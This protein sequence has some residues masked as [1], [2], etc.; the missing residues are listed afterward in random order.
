[1][2]HQFDGSMVQRPHCAPSVIASTR[3]RSDRRDQCSAPHWSL[4]PR[5]I[6]PATR[7]IAALRNESIDPAFSRTAELLPKENVHKETA[8]HPNLQDKQSHR[9]KASSTDAPAASDM[10]AIAEPNTISKKNTP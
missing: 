6:T 2:S 1:M 10:A 8:E 4:K 5:K 9:D 7:Q 3:R